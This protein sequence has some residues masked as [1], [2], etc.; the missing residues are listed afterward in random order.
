M[1]V[2][3]EFGRIAGQHSRVMA[4]KIKMGSLHSV[5]IFRH[6]EPTAWSTEQF[7]DWMDTAAR[8]S[9]Q[10]PDKKKKK[11]KKRGRRKRRL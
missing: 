6:H 2:D 7:L 4:S 3:D 5:L 8:W 9:A 10:T 1:A 11:K